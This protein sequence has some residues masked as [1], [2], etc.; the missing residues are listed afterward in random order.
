MK[1]LLVRRGDRLLMLETVREY[2]LELLTQDP[3]CDAM[4]HRLAGWGLAFLREATPHLVQADRATWVTRLDAELP[5]LL[6]ALSW[7]LEARRVEASLLLVGELGEYWFHQHGWEDGLVWIDASLEL[8][9]HDF[10]HLRAKALLY[11]ARLN[12]VR[13]QDQ[14]Y[15]DDLH[16]S[17]ELFRACDDPGGIAA[18]LG[19]LAAA[20]WWI[21]HDQQAK[22]FAD[23]A[24]SIAQSAH[25]EGPLAQAL[26]E[27]AVAAPRYGDACPQARAA[28]AALRRVDNLLDVARVC[29]I[30]G[31]RAIAEG[32]YEAALAWLEEGL[33]VGRQLGSPQAVF[34]IRCTQGLAQLFLDDVDEAAEGFS[35]ALAICQEAACEDLVEEPLLGLAAV[36]V[37]RGDPA[38]AAHLAAAAKAHE[39]HG[40][41][42]DENTAY[43]RLIDELTQA[44]ERYGSQDW[45]RT[46]RQGSSLTVQESIDIALAR[47]QFSPSAA[48]TVPPSST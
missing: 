24:I 28:V 9:G 30:T 47:G 22:A 35:D 17:L 21:G 15:R 31:G 41:S 5:N 40:H 2:A 42:L 20:E 23:E 16:T 10:P 46:V 18:C 37:R 27:S 4:Q 29:N 33:E 44:R 34:F 6:A 1:Q 39:A 13:R 7:A 11:R 8:A 14:R 48:I 26:T 19:H 36:A 43:A 25:D 12:G 32:R 3:D 45:D 38:R